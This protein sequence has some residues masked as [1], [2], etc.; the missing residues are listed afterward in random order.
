MILDNDEAD[1]RLASPDNVVR[2]FRNGAGPRLGKERASHEVRDTA[3]AL[4][5]MGVPNQ[6]VA[7]RL[8]IEYQDVANYAHNRKVG[9]GKLKLDPSEAMDDVRQAALNKLM[10]AMGL[11]TEEKLSKLKAPA[12]AGVASKMSAII[13]RTMPKEDHNERNAVTLVVYAPQVKEESSFKVV[14]I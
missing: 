3:V 5:K 11:I 4:H 14:E 9:K 7:D 10:C 13:E 1:E 6:E 12:L 8:G 2:S